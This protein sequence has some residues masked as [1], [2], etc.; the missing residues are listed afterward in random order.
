MVKKPNYDRAAKAFIK[1]V[2]QRR[3]DLIIKEIDQGLS[4]EE[5]DELHHLQK[6]VGAVIAL[7]Y[8]LS[9]AFR[10]LEKAAGIPSPCLRCG[11]E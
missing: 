3:C 5:A 11:R 6:A 2:N 7:A 4:D 1:K 8:P 10:D 9:F